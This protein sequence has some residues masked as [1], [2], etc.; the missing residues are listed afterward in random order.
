MEQKQVKFI[1]F[2]AKNSGIIKAVELTPDILSRK[3]VV[4]RGESGA[5]KSSLMKLIQTAVSGTEAIA[6]KNVLE[7]S[8]Y[9]TNKWL[10]F[11]F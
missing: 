10:T 2:N 5:G 7:N 9:Q 4:V 1:G 8:M 6:S 11:N 3:M